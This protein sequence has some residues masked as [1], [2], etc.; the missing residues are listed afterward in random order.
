MKPP[1]AKRNGGK[2][3]KRKAQDDAPP[4][5]LEEGEVC[6][7]AVLQLPLAHQY[8][9][10]HPA[11]GYPPQQKGYSDPYGPP[12]AL[13]E[14]EVVPVVL[15]LLSWGVHPGYLI[16]SGVSEVSITNLVT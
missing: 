16:Q 15:E 12:P 7:Q 13:S 8:P 6:P 10:P 9:P 2:N 4:P 1:Q 11:Q 5:E 3:K 14:A